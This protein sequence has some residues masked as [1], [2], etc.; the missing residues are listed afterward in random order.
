VTVEGADVI[1]TLPD[2]KKNQNVRYNRAST[3]A[4]HGPRFDDNGYRQGPARCR[5]HI[6]DSAARAE[7]IS[8][9]IRIFPIRSL[10]TCRSA[11]GRVIAGELRT[12]AA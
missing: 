12:A 4:R 6:G 7:W 2:E 8:F 11:I 9:D 1:V 3:G 5:I 10:L